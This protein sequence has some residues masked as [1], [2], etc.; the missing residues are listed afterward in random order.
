MKMVEVKSKTIECTITNKQITTTK[1]KNAKS[2]RQAQTVNWNLLH[3]IS[4]YK[5][6]KMEYLIGILT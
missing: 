2:K 3:A 4:L 6:I 1:K 5:Y